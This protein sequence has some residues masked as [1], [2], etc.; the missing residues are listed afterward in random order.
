MKKLFILAFI[1]TLILTSCS[2]SN[3]DVV[4]QP[5]KDGSVETVM[6][7]RHADSFDILTTT[8]EV[9]VKGIVLKFIVRNDTLPSLGTTTQEGEDNN[10]N[11]QNITVPKDYEIYLT[12][13]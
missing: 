11:T 3:D 9:W 10:G 12:V 2:D 4:S 7:I 1:S 5:N 6:S 13:K 8:H